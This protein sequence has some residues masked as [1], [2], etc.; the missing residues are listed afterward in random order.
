[1]PY[2]ASEGLIGFGKESTWGQVADAETFV[3]VVS[4]RLAASNALVAPEGAAGTKMR[5]RL[6]Q[7]VRRIEGELDMLPT[8]EALGQALVMLFGEPVT[9]ELTDGVY[10]HVFQGEPGEAISASIEVNLG[11][12]K[13]RQI[14]GCKAET[15]RLGFPQR[16]VLDLTLGVVGKQESLIEPSSFELAGSE[17]LSFVG[18]SA[19]FPIGTACG[20]VSGGEIVIYRGLVRDWATLGSGTEIAKLPEGKRTTS[21]RVALDFENTTAYEAFL[22]AEWKSLKVAFAGEEIATGYNAALVIE[23]P[24]LRIESP[25]LHLHGPDGLLV[26]EL[27]CEAVVDCSLAT[28]T[29]VKVTLVNTTE[30]Y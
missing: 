10:Q 7:G 1:M 5:K 2:V 22:D 23:A 26:Q 8:P 11:G 12:F 28:P 14:V 19:E 29:D 18:G 6:L 16:N 30:S 27:I 15:L 21:L 4:E 24:K 25:G 17:P 3:E 13:S 20:D 9:T